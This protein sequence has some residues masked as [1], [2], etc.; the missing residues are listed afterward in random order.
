MDEARTELANMALAALSHN[1][2]LTSL[3]DDNSMLGKM[4]RRFIDIARLEALS[5]HNWLFATK[6]STS[7]GLPTPGMGG[8]YMHYRT[9]DMLRIVSMHDAI[10]GID[11]TTGL[12]WLAGTDGAMFTSSQSV[13][14]RHIY[15]HN[16]PGAW[17]PLFKSA[18]SYRLAFHL[19]LPVTKSVKAKSS[20][21]EAFGDAIMRARSHDLSDSSEQNTGFELG[22]S[23][24]ILARENG[25]S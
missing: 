19:A 5:E 18:V 13:I 4:C 17:P 25:N 11:S 6:L 10:A 12:Q 16:T 22:A 3:D 8:G 7:G 20:M 9:H 2:I 21:L 23:Q 15:P 14:V 24:L 1:Q